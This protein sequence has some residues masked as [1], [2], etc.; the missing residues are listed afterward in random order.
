MS[1]FYWLIEY[2]RK[3]GWLLRLQR[4]TDRKRALDAR[5][6]LERIR[7]GQDIEVVV[8]GASKLSDILR[9]HSR[10]FSEL[11]ER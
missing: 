8:L 5:F 2:H 9:T 1:A 3:P 10:Y 4:F 11:E 7:A 6:D